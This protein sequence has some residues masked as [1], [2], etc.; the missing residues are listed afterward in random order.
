MTADITANSVTGGPVMTD[1]STVTGGNVAT[2]ADGI[3][4]LPDTS[5]AQTIFGTSNGVNLL[6]SDSLALNFNDGANQN[7]D[8]S[9]IAPNVWNSV[10][11]I[12]DDTGLRLVHN[13]GAIRA[14][15]WVDYSATPA[16]ITSPSSGAPATPSH[17]MASSPYSR[18]TT[19]RSATPT[20]PTTLQG[21][22]R[23]RQA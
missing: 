12:E 23:L 11:V 1:Q 22:W 2:W 14:V 13:G 15:N 5:R 19:S 21:W 4:T 8:V 3:A 7:V 17:S 20:C 6:S 9:S 16:A 10:V 18:P